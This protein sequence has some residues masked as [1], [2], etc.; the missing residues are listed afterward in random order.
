MAVVHRYFGVTSAGTGDGTSWAN[1]AALLTSPTGDWSSVIK[2]FD[3]SGSDSLVCWIGPGTYGDDT[4]FLDG[5]SPGDFTNPP[6]QQNTLTL[7]ACDS[8]GDPWEPP[9]PN[10]VSA[11][12][13]WDTSDM[14]E[15]RVG[16]VGIFDSMFL[17]AYGLRIVASGLTVDTLKEGGHAEWVVIENNSSGTSLSMVA[18]N[19]WTSL[20]NCCLLMNGTAFEKFMDIATTQRYIDNVRME[21][22]ASPSGGNRYGVEKRGNTTLTLSR[23]TVVGCAVAFR[24]SSNGTNSYLQLM[25]CMAINSSGDGVVNINNNSDC[26]NSILAGCVVVGSGGYGLRATVQEQ[27]R[28]IGSRLRDNTSGNTT[29]GNDPLLGCEI[30]AGTDAAEF[31]DAANGD[32]RIK[33]TSTLWGRGIGAGDEPASGGGGSPVTTGYAI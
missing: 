13:C 25:R 7:A 12:P 32:Y 9:D 17:W 1:R 27:I 2:S 21:A 28:A 6:T 8:S 5:L 24:H 18:G 11:Q 26:E 33:N 20:K 4:F 14:P 29:N 23:V 31:V 10:W 3:F 30:G 15:I 22:T 16:N 19:G